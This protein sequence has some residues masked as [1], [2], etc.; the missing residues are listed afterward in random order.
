MKTKNLVT[1]LMVA[2]LPVLLNAQPSVSDQQVKNNVEKKWSRIVKAYADCLEKQNEGILETSFV[3]ILQLK[4]N[5][6]EKDL[7]LLENKI[8]ML[9]LSGKSENIRYKAFLVSTFMK[10]A[11]W[12]QDFDYLKNMRESVYEKNTPVFEDLTKV[13]LAK[14]IKN[15]E[16]SVA[17][18]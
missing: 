1:I 4:V 17:V 9:V 7:S 12:L 11:D 2:A 6:P 15:G 16:R 8:D 10:K 3:W 13:M 14:V 5:F 18:Q